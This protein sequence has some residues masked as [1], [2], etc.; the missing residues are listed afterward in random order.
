MAE[1]CVPNTEFLVQCTEC[2]R[3]LPRKSLVILSSTP[4]EH[5]FS[6][7]KSCAQKLE[8][9][10]PRQC[11]EC[12]RKQ[13]V[14]VNANSEHPCK[15]YSFSSSPYQRN[16]CYNNI[17]ILAND[18]MRLTAMASCSVSSGAANV[19]DLPEVFSGEQLTATNE[20]CYSLPNLHPLAEVGYSQDKDVLVHHVQFETRMHQ[21]T[22]QSDSLDV[23]FYTEMDDQPEQHDTT[24]LLQPAIQ[25]FHSPQPG[26]PNL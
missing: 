9:A 4:C 2:N 17:I 8:A 25:R 1:S 10:P 26:V 11:P 6:A 12:I 16:C 15:N 18:Y 21:H 19:C 20:Q 13:P 3:T 22:L 7:C 23:L 14:Q 24:S 5:R